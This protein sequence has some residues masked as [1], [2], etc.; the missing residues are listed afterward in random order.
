V[1]LAV[2]L[3]NAAIG[4]VQEGRA[5]AAMAA[6]RQMLAPR[7]AVLRDGHR[8]SVDGADLVPG[9]IVLLEAGDKV[10]AD[11]RVIEA[12]GLAAQEAI[13][14][15]ESV[16]V[17]KTA[18]P[19]PADAALGDRRSMM[20][21]G[22]LVTQGTARGVVVATGARTEIGRIGGLLA[23]VEQLTTPL[24]AQMDHFA[25]WLSFLILLVSGLLLLYGYYVGHHGFSD[26][27]MAVVGLAVAA[28]PEG[29]SVAAI[30]ALVRPSATSAMIRASAR[31]MRGGADRV[32]GG[33][34]GG[35][36]AASA[37][38]SRIASVSPS[39]ASRLVIAMMASES[40]SAVAA[41]SAASE[42]VQRLGPCWWCSPTA[43]HHRPST[44][45]PA[46]RL[47]DSYL[48]RGESA[49]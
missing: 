14:T 5:E 34:R 43:P 33:R 35:G 8:A 11:L 25:R 6:I 13:L 19:V 36:A 38:R 9:D 22:T 10:P 16:P 32:A 20:W 40:K 47:T 44:Q 2:V 21:S 15:G 4:F 41:T 39:T 31:V 23:E 24:V 49:E 46:N 18:E 12:R 42:S 29:L 1:I 28:I 45:M 26:L 30:S 27:F 17:D 48:K 7:A 3:A 37:S